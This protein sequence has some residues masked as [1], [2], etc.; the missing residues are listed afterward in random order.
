MCEGWPIPRKFIRKGNF[1]YKFKIKEDY[2]Y[3]SG[4]KLEKPFVSEWL[5]IST[6]GRITI[7]ASEEKPYCW[8]G[9]SPKRSMLNL[10]IFGTPDGHV[11]HRTMKPYTYYAS[12]VH[13][14]LY[15]YL[16]CVPVTKEKIDLLFLEMLGDFKLRRVYH[17]FVKHLGGR[18]V[19]Q[20]GID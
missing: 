17:F 13:D 8:D 16:D 15:Q 5:E 9:C 11:D 1:P 7:K 20:K 3:E 19:I 18:G 14:A 2:P 6:S 10:F 12:L 4:W